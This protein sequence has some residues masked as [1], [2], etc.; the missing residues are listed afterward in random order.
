[1]LQF[2]YQAWESGYRRV[3]GLDEAGR[4]PL[5][6]PVV[7]VALVF[8][9]AFVCSRQHDLFAALTDSKQL[10]EAQRN[11]FY[12]LLMESPH[13]EVGLGASGPEEI[14]AVNIL[15]ATHLAMAR[16]VANLLHPPDHILVDGLFVPGL[17]C[18]STPIVDGDAK[19]LSI[20]AAS[21]IAKVSRDDMMRDLDRQYPEYGFAEHKGYG[22][23]AHTQAL[24]DHGPSPVHR[25]TFRPVRE[26]MRIR[27]WMQNN[28]HATG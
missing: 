22:T 10:T 4:G 25:K 15:R 12:R 23:K 20:A 7:A 24:L 17:L 27:S 5:A 28:G 14:D 16:A 6:G 13:V 1:M 18:S 9:R 11:R 8:D 19:S 2:E 3:A 26:I 21:V